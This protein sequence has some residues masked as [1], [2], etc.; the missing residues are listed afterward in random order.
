MFFL[1]IFVSPKSLNTSRSNNNPSND[2]IRK[3]LGHPNSICIKPPNPGANKGIMDIP[4]VTYP[5]I[6]AASF[7]DVISR[8]ITLL[9]K[10]PAAIEAC[11][12]L[13]KIKNSNFVEK[14][15]P[16]EAIIKIIIENK[17]IILLPNLS[18]KGPAII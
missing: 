8:I 11:R 9:I 12:S 4:I 1:I 10:N 13:K 15:Q 17:V 6:E 18:D 5:I 16:S 2:I 3:I 14:K 7:S